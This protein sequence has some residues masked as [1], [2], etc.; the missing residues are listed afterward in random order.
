[1][2]IQVLFDQADDY[3]YTYPAEAFNGT[4][5][6]FLITYIAYYIDGKSKTTVQKEVQMYISEQPGELGEYLKNYKIGGESLQGTGDKNHHISL[7]GILAT[8]V[9]RNYISGRSIEV[10]GQEHPALQINLNDPKE[11][12]SSVSIT[13]D[14]E[15]CIGRP[16]NSISFAPGETYEG[17]FETFYLNTANR[18]AINVTL[19]VFDVNNTKLAEQTTVIT[20]RD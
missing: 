18:T 4:S 6:K 3:S 8:E 1:M 12:A 14:T 16:P 2:D 11:G 19:K 9:W 10:D 13:S 7:I 20:I 15:F 5:Q 17:G